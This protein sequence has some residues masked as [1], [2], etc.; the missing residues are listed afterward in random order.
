M[1]IWNQ[2]RKYIKMSTN[3]AMFGPVVLEIACCISQT[4]NPLTHVAGVHYENV[5]SKKYLTKGRRWVILD[6]V[7]F[8]ASYHSV[9]MYNYYV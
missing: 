3:K 7:M 4:S 5:L 6:G 2:C 9:P 8:P 1:N